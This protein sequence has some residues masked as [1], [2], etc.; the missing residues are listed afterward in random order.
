MGL[1]SFS[2]VTRRLAL[3]SI[4]VSYWRETLLCGA[5]EM[6][7]CLRALAARLESIGWIPSLN[8]G[9]QVCITPVPG[10]RTPSSDLQEYQPCM[11]LIHIYVDKTLIHIKRQT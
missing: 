6:D 10:G 7:Q 2:G 5:A 3:T 9:S 8:C 11:W 1:S 4:I